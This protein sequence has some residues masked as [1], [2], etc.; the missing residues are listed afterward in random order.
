MTSKLT[1]KRSKLIVNLSF[2]NFVPNELCESFIAVGH[3]FSD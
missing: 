2:N 1:L 3:A